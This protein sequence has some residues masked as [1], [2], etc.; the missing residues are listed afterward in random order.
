MLVYSKEANSN[1]LSYQLTGL[2]IHANSRQKLIIIAAG[3]ISLLSCCQEVGDALP[4][5][6]FMALMTMC[7]SVG[8]HSVSFADCYSH[9][10]IVHPLFLLLLPILLF[11]RFELKPIV[12]E[13]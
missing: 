7:S 13:I 5:S 4:L 2:P 12:S 8:T 11:F 10:L 3:V 6:D 9:G 1:T